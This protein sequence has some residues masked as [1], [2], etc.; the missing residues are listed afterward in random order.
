MIPSTISG[1]TLEIFWRF[2]RGDTPVET[3]EKW[4]Y[5]SPELEATLGPEVYLDMISVDFRDP[6]ATAALVYRLLDDLPPIAACLCHT[7]RN[8]D[9]TGIGT[10]TPWEFM[11]V[12]EP[13]VEAINWLQRWQCRICGTRWIA[14]ADDIGYDTWTLRRGWEIDWPHAAGF[15]NLRTA[16]HDPGADVGA[17]APWRNIE[18]L[19]AVRTLAEIDPGVALSRIACILNVSKA[20][21]LAPAVSIMVRHR[22]RINLLR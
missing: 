21:V 8:C 2:A 13:R 16:I 3:F 22:C 20:S 18:I 1:E 19:G 5:A 14:A 15:R 6:Q 7:L 9:R 10:D 12:K 17:Q 4:L 11:E